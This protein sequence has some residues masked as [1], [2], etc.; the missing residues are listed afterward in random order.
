LLGQDGQRDSK[1]GVL[2]KSE[3]NLDDRR[4]YGFFS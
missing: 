3:E 1:V 4:A 2:Y